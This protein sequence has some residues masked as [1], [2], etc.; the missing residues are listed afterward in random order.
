MEKITAEREAETMAETTAETT[1]ETGRDNGRDAE[2][3]RPGTKQTN[4][5]EIYDMGKYRPKFNCAV[6][7]NNI[8]ESDIKKGFAKVLRDTADRIEREPNGGSS[9]SCVI[10]DARGKCRGLWSISAQGDA[11][12][13]A[14]NMGH[15]E[16]MNLPKLKTS[17][18]T[19]EER[20]EYELNCQKRM[21]YRK[22]VLND[23]VLYELEDKSWAGDKYWVQSEAAL[24]Q[25]FDEIKIEYYN[26]P[27]ETKPN[28]H[29]EWLKGGAA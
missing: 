13:E 5:Y 21:L 26:G 17:D 16:K 23:D 20:A 25:H 19:P 24:S 7:F 22:V 15:Y 11:F 1:A 4:L 12:K 9:V 29:E 8:H 18:M 3:Q 10:R 14:Q 6:V 28:G 27:R 2:T